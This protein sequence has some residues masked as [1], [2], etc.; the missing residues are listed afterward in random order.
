MQGVGLHGEIMIPV[1]NN[2][3][4][5]LRGPSGSGKT[6]VAKR[7]F[8]LTER[9][10]ALIQ[11]DHYRFIFKPAGGGGQ[12][13]SCVIHQMIEHNC[14]CALAD[15]YD[16]I[17]EGILSVKSYEAVL[18]R[19]IASHSGPSSIF[20]F[21]VS[22]EETAHRHESRRSTCNFTVED[23]RLWY[24]D[25]HRSNHRLEKIIPE[26]YSEAEIVKFICRETSLNQSVAGR[27]KAI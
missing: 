21:D 6:T 22:F 2:H 5:I 19:I 16:V 11:Q 17:L 13:N 10:T 14:T 3:F 15:G 9:R 20:Y 12:H 8:A 18:D 4:I 24:A 7:L 1:R 27:E 26:H 25:S 23:M